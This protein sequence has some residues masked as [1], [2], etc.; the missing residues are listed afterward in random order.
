[1]YIL[2]II[3]LVLFFTKTSLSL[4]ADFKYSLD[5]KSKP[6]SSSSREDFSSLNLDKIERFIT[7]NNIKTAGELLAKIPPSELKQH[8]LIYNTNSPQKSTFLRP[9][10]V[11]FGRDAKFILAFNDLNEQMEPFF[12]FDILEYSED[13]GSYDP[14]TIEFDPIGIRVAKVNRSPQTC[15]LCHSSFLGVQPIRSSYLGKIFPGVYQSVWARPH[16]GREQDEHARYLSQSKATGRY[17]FLPEPTAPDDGSW[18]SLASPAFML[19]R[20]LNSNHFVGL[21]KHISDNQNLNIYRYAILAALQCV[22]DAGGDSLNA[23]IEDYLPDHIKTGFKYSYQSVKDELST[24][25]MDKYN[26]RLIGRELAL[27]EELDSRLVEE[28]KPELDIPLYSFIYLLRNVVPEE[29]NLLADVQFLVSAGD[30]GFGG[31]RNLATAYYKL[32]LN[33]D[34]DNDLKR[35]FSAYEKT[36]QFKYQ[37]F[38]ITDLMRDEV[39]SSLRLKSLESLKNKELQ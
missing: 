32:A 33:E 15:I 14:A 25:A 8:L 5:L 35:L 30:D 26:L 11:S 12:T 27:G 18:G 3:L 13:K 4:S 1:M 2:K 38:R 29:S 9:R 17:Q 22:S 19:G 39:C 36:L 20:I 37:S 16:I 34:L 24:L 31:I 6:R 28:L 23:Q 10:V 21:A 7:D